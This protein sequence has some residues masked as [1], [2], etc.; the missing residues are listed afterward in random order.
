[1]NNI[2]FK[3]LITNATY[4]TKYE[5]IVD[6]QTD[7]VYAYEALSKFNLNN[8]VM[9]T[10]DIFRKLHHNNELFYTLEK[11]NKEL[12]I[13]HFD[14]D[15]KL[16]VNFDADIFVTNEQ[17]AYW[18]KFLLE[19]Q[20]RVVVEIT[21][22]GN[23]DEASAKIIREFASWLHKKELMSALDDFGQDG[24]MFS[25]HIMNRCQYI[26]LD[27]SFIKQIKFNMNYIPFLKGLLQTIR[28]N[29][30]KSIIEGVETY[31]DY[32]FVKTLDCDYMQGH[33]FNDLIIE[34]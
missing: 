3:H 14:S 19:H 16:F 22:N 13:K 17:K 7:D 30:Q 21:E 5:P 32:D 26:K 2:E 24:S 27:R 15:K 31:A 20:K 6:V 1:M 34:R 25:F 18:E 10:E 33:Y 8:R 11:R 29:N 12:Q 28:M 23:D 9:S 4:S